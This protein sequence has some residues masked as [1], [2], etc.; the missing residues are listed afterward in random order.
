MS[1]SML[2]AGRAA[3][4]IYSALAR[5]RAF[6]VTVLILAAG[7]GGVAAVNMRIDMSFRPVFTNDAEELAATAEFE[8]T[9]G[10]VGFN[11]L[12]VMADVGTAAEPARVR[13]PPGR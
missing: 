11:D 3:H 1:S 9:F 6:V 12:F 13:R 4:R 10:E 2:L 7:A 5:H 8:K